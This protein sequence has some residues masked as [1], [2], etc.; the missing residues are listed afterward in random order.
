MSF[1][2]EDS[3]RLPYNPETFEDEQRV[4]LRRAQLH[5][6]RMNSASGVAGV[7]ARAICRASTA[8][9]PSSHRQLYREADAILN[10]CG[11]QDSIPTCSRATHPL[12]RERSGVE[13]IKVDR[14]TDRPSNI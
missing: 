3:A 2:I 5:I 13:Q 6:S 9:L 12:H 1:Y 4:R 7:F 14:V 8:G 11:T 10:V